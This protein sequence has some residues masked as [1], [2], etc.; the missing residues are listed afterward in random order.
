MHPT[1]EKITLMRY[2][3]ISKLFLYGDKM[4]YENKHSLSADYFAVE[5]G[6][7]FEFPAHI[8][9]CFE[10][11]C[12]LEGEMQVTIDRSSYELS[13][14]D[15][16]MIFSNQMHQMNT[17]VHSKHILVLF[18]PKLISAYA[19]KTSGMI[20]TQ[21]KFRPSAF[22]IEK[23]NSVSNGSSLIEQ[24]GLLYSLCG[25]FDKCTSYSDASSAEVSGSS[26]TLLYNI[27]RF[28][29]N[30]YS[31][32]CSLSDLA[33]STGYDYAYLSR[34]FRKAV[35]ISYNDYVNQHRISKSCY[36]L[37]NTEMTVLE[38]SN[39]CGLGSLRS[40]NRIF[41]EQLGVPP[42]EYRKRLREASSE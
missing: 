19:E 38:I 5:H 22:Y 9:H 26:G 37:A 3:Q 21:S 28:I 10:L 27:F 30:N 24:K 20:P 29:E 39:E 40:F 13:A 42:A 41:K 12:V 35:G 7:D 11:L 15:A 14:G 16:V 32:S 17:P 2:N 25:E 36:L 1:I 8:H 18:S 4:F 33:R 34:Y 6:T 23:L 31:K